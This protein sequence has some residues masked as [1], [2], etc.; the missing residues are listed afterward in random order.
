[1]H[2]HPPR[3][4]R[5]ERPAADTAVVVFHGEHDIA[6]K[7][8][9]RTLLESLVEENA[10]VVA[11]F[12]DATFVDSTTIH[13]LLGAHAAAQVRGKTFR[14]QLGTA[15]IVRTAFEL[16]GVLNRVECASSRE[17]ALRREPVARS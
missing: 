9:L 7:K 10:L 6:S 5:I 2:D 15:T 1:M 3:D 13:L 16:T 17:E 12:T 4:I 8:E 14:V 11:D